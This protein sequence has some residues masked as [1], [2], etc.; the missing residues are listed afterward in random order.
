MCL[1]IAL[2]VSAG[3]GA[4]DS[5]ADDGVGASVGSVIPLMAANFSLP[6]FDKNRRQIFF[7]DFDLAIVRSGTE[8]GVGLKEYS[9]IANCTFGRGFKRT[10]QFVYLVVCFSLTKEMFDG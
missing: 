4:D 10:E 2:L 6:S 1:R 8:I 5:G 3:V 9:V 7:S